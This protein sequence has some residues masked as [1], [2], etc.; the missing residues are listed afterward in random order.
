MRQ[1]ANDTGWNPY[2]A[3]ALTGVVIVLS[4]WLTGKYA[5]VST[6]FVRTAGMLEQLVAPERVAAMAYFI[7]TVPKIEWQWMFVAGI[8]IGAGIASL[9]SGNFTVRAVPA[10]WESRFGPVIGK[11]ALFAFMGGLTGMFGAR[12]A[13]G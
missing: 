2:V 12:L 4:V 11:R 10:M 7:K 13:G 3:G 6:S 1:Q 8:F 9:S 5:G